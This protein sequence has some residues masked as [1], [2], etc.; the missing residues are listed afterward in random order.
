MKFYAFLA[1][2]L[3]ILVL[4]FLPRR[5]QFVWVKP[6]TT[7]T[8]VYQYT[9]EGGFWRDVAPWLILGFEVGRHH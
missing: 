4:A 6:Q 1:F 5:S 3:V 7:V 8:R 2:L 9:P